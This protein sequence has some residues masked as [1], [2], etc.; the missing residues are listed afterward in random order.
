MLTQA[1]SPAFEGTAGPGGKPTDEEQAVTNKNGPSNSARA[2]TAYPA[3][4]L[5]DLQLVARH[6]RIFQPLIQR[7]EKIRRRQP[8][9]H[10]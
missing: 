3:E 2:T 4:K 7:G 8:S 10:R 6:L 1:H 5:E 9:I